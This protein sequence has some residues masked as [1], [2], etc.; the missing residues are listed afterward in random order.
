ME[1]REGEFSPAEDLVWLQ[2]V[3]GLVEEAEVGF[4]EDDA[5]EVVCGGGA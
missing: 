4:G 1:G 5:G 2:V 3:E